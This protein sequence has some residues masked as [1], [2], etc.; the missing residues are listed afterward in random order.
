MVKVDAH[1]IFNLVCFKEIIKIDKFV[2]CTIIIDYGHG[3]SSFWNY[4][5]VLQLLWT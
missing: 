3:T 4:T 1:P 5:A 2:R